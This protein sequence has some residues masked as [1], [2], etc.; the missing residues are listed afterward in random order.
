MKRVKRIIGTLCILFPVFLFL[1]C[2]VMLIGISDD[3]EDGDPA[4]ASGL[5]L[6]DK[7]REYAAFVGDTAAEYNIHEYEK[8]LLAIMM[9]E[10]G[11]E[12]NDP[13]Q[14]L[15]NSGLTEEEKTPSES[16]KAAVAYFAMLLQKAD[17]LGCDLDAVIQAY[18]YGAGYIDY[19]SVRGKAHTFQLSCDF[20]SSKCGGSIIIRLQS[21]RMVAGG[22]TMETCFMYIL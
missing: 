7:V 22:M 19:V 11:G 1:I 2:G 10:S 15:G 9:V 8:Y 21:H 5:G 6:S 20:A 16:I 4:H 12:G 17:T 14:S 13:M 18:N 3:G